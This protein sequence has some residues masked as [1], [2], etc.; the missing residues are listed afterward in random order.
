MLRTDGCGRQYGG[1]YVYTVGDGH[2]LGYSFGTHDGDGSSCADSRGDGF[3]FGYR[4]GDGR[5]DGYGADGGYRYREDPNITVLVIDNNPL[6][7][8]YQAH[9]MQTIKDHHA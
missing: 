2:G 9:S 7:T 4:M 6:T 1:D 5:G 3:I 8:A